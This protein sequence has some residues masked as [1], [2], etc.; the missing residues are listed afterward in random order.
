MHLPVS[1]SIRRLYLK[2]LFLEVILPPKSLKQS[3]PLRLG[4][5][6]AVWTSCRYAASYFSMP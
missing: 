3:D 1:V 5:K 4:I 6:M 2:S